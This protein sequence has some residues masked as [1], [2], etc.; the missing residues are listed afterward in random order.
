MST[1]VLDQ[2][3]AMPMHNVPILQEDTSA[4]VRL[5]SKEMAQLVLVCFITIVNKVLSTDLY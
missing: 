5:V 4:S 3:H 1:S 2:I